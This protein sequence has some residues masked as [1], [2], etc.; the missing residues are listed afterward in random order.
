MD[1]SQYPAEAKGLRTVASSAVQSGQSASFKLLQRALE[2]DGS[3]VP[4]AGQL[5]AAAG[6]VNGTTTN[7]T[8]GFSG[9]VLSGAGGKKVPG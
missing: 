5:P 4:A 9:G 8:A 3:A 2:S 6:P 7:G 1:P